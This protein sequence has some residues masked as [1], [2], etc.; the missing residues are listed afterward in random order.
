MWMLSETLS[1]LDRIV[2]LGQIGSLARMRGPKTSTAGEC[3]MPHAT[4]G[5]VLQG[6]ASPQGPP[7]QS[8]RAFEMRE[9]R[10]PRSAT[11]PLGANSASPRDLRSAMD[12]SAAGSSRTEPRSRPDDR[13]E[14][15]L[16]ETACTHS[17][18]HVGAPRLPGTDLSCASG[19]VQYH[20]RPL[21]TAKMIDTVAGRL[22]P[23]VERQRRS[24]AIDSQGLRARR[25]SQ[26]IRR[27]YV[28]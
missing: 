20:P 7:T 13:L 24:K 16:V 10:L 12:T 11:G 26:S 19:L 14:S 2:S 27:R 22:S 4:L 15:T 9:I 8:P 6:P 28:F 17:V 1:G 25:P 21:S 5:S 23:S 18:Q 3:P